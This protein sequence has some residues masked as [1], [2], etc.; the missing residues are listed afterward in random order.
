MRVCLIVYD[1]ESYIHHPPVALMYIASALRNA[2]HDVSVYSQDLYH[3]P[4]SHLT[5]YLTRNHFDAIGLSLVAGYYPYRK[6]LKISEA[7]NKVPNRPFYILGGHGPSPEPEYF[8]KKSGSDCVVVGEG[9]ITIV[10]LLDALENKRPLSSVRGIAY[11][12]SG[13]LVQTGRQ[14]LIPD[15][16]KIP[17]PS[18]D[19]FPMDYYALYRVG[20]ITTNTDRVGVVISGRG[21]PFHCNF[22]YRM[23][24]GSRIRSPESIIEEI[25]ILKKDYS[26][27]FILFQDELLM[28]S[29]TRTEAICQAFIKA[30]LNMK[31]GCNGRLNFAKPDIIRLMKQAGCVF[32]NYGIESVDDDALRNMNKSLTVK[33][34]VSGIEATEAGG[35][36]PGFNIIFGNIGETREIL[37]KDVDFLLK[38][39]DQGQVRTIRPVTPYPGSPLYYHAIE[40][41]LLKGCA[42]FYENKHINQDLPSVNVANLSDVEFS[43]ALYEANT[44]LLDNYFEKQKVKMLADCKKLYI[45]KDENFR[46]FRQT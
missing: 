22:C 15:I 12:E 6:L 26:I 34:I 39:D 44:T 29:T 35:I 23:D 7:V 9:E 18:W 46:G 31:W 3:W 37:Q 25:S 40:K 45:D 28:T 32:I 33:Q 16:N 13:K 21:C 20:N 2:G 14:P 5:D 27:N 36:H 17:F 1:N 43:C 41:G 4:E 11:M 10:N 30:N 8:L 24:E 38:Y 19:L 42:D